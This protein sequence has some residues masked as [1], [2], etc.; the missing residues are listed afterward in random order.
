MARTLG[1]D[2]NQVTGGGRRV[3]FA[4]LGQTPASM[5]IGRDLSVNDDY[6][7]LQQFIP[8]MKT[9]RLQ[10]TDAG[11][12][13]VE[14]FAQFQIPTGAVSDLQP[15][16]VEVLKG[17]N[18][19]GTRIGVD[20]AKGLVMVDGTT[21]GNKDI[22]AGPLLPG[23]ATLVSIHAIIDHSIIEVIV[24]N[25]TALTVYVTPSSDQSVG[26]ALYGTEDNGVNLGKVSGDLHVWEL[27]S[28]NHQ[29][30]PGPHN[31]LVNPASGM[32]ADIVGGSHD[33]EASVQLYTCNDGGAQEWELQGGALVNPVSGK[34]LDISNPE[35]LKP[36]EYKD[37]TKVQLFTCNGRQNQKW[38]FQD[39]K[40]VNP[41]SGKCLDI[42]SPSGD[43]HSGARLQ[44]FTCGTGKSNQAWEQVHEMPGILI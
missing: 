4:W 15:F 10:E 27:E 13:Q 26:V 6:E 31:T 29:Y 42:P 21:Q 20:P 39:G 43:L 2:V 3:M 32:C 7:L 28:A 18:G 12:Q 11:G 34:C 23:D 22:R 14:V 36:E 37:E 19:E 35:Y 44:L 8:E 40:L 9:L 25:R 24:N 17:S 30:L 16:G 41:P 33:D 38:A 1:G 5:S